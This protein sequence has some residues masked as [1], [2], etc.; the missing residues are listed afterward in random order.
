MPFKVL[1]NITVYKISLTYVK[2]VFNDHPWDPKIVIF[3][4]WFFV[5]HLC[6]KSYRKGAIQIIRADLGWVSAKCNINY[7]LF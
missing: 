2:L 7:F 5:V 1:Y 4:R 6:S 3:E